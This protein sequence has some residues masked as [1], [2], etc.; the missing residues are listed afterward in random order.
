M[1]DNSDTPETCPAPVTQKTLWLRATGQAACALV[2][3]ALVLVTVYSI[4]FF[5]FHPE[6]APFSGGT[7]EARAIPG[8]MLQPMVAGGGGLQGDTAVITALA[9]GKQAVLAYQGGFDAEDFPFIQ[10]E[11]EGLTRFTTAFVYWIRKDDPENLHYLP[12][13]RSGDGVTQVA[14]PYGGENYRGRIMELG[15]AFTDGPALGV[16]NNKG[17]HIKVHRL[18]MLP[19]SAGA[20]AHQ[21]WKD[22]VNPPLWKGYSNNIV[23]GIHENGMVFPN[24]VLNLLVATSAIFFLAWRL[25]SPTRLRANFSITRAVLVTIGIC[26]LLGDLLRWQW[27]IEQLKD[28]HERYAG[29][30]LEER[31]RNNP[32]RCARFPEDCR[33]DLLP[34]F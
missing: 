21:I 19:F 13:N 6:F 17:Q 20:V 7:A 10:F 31:I 8:R 33:A 26:W 14:M 3:S 18:E 4:R 15:I 34:Y 5:D 29:L 30:P 1:Q 27:R 16:D 9:D 32:I 11:L 2:L 24:L 23:R 12:L 28:T 22:W 25:L